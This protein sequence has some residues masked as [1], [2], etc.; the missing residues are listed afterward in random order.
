VRRN[1]VI[2]CS[3][4]AVLLLSAQAVSAAPDE[5]FEE[6]IKLAPVISNADRKY[7]RIDLSVSYSV[8]D[9]G[10]LSLRVQYEAP[11]RFALRLTDADDGTPI[12][13]LCERK[14]LM[15]DAVDGAVRCFDSGSFIYEW[16]RRAGKLNLHYRVARRGPPC[17]ILLDLKSAYDEKGIADE[18]TRSGKGV[19]NLRRNLDG[20]T[21]FTAVVDRSRACPFR[22]IGVERAES[23]ENRQHCAYFHR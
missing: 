1:G 19:F 8:A 7:Q 15:Y 4:A 22:E 16:G 20:Q 23:R 21:V 6:L 3:L 2:P 13:Y 9:W 18:L 12:V 5:T 17:F 11:D 10:K 14:L